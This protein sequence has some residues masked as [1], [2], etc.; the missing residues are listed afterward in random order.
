MVLAENK[1]RYISTVNNTVKSFKC[2]QATLD[3]FGSSVIQIIFQICPVVPGG[4]HCAVWGRK[5][6][7]RDS[8]FVAI[9]KAF[10]VLLLQACLKRFYLSIRDQG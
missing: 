9:V 2:V 1:I 8:Y 10:K 6:I 5:K 3:L 4:D 7:P